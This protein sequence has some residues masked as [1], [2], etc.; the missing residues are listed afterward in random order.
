MGQVQWGG[1]VQPVRE[2][3]SGPASRGGVRS[4]WRGEGG[5]GPAG[6]GGSAK[7]GQQNE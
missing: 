3:G 2:G 1:Q 5:S 6:R 7:I 4:S